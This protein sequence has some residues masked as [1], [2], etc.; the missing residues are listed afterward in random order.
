MA[1]KLNKH[2][3]DSDDLLK[4]LETNDSGGLD[5]FEK[6]ALEGFA[7]LENPELARKLNSQLTDKLNEVYFEKKQ[8]KKTFFRAGHRLYSILRIPQGL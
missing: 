4:R 2:T 5:D 7:S 8:G 3:P 1:Q 6:E